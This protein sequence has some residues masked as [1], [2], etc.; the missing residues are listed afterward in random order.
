MESLAEIEKNG[1]TFVTPNG[2]VQVSPFLSIAR[3]CEKEIR[4]FCGEFGMTPAS[5][6]KV[7]ATPKKENEDDDF[8][9]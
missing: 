1:M 5:R 8:F 6:S 7:D 3:Y 2:S 4:Q 9:D